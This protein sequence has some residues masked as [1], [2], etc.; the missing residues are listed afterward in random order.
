M[1][2]FSSNMKITCQF[3]PEIFQNFESYRDHIKS[4]HSQDTN[5]NIKLEQITLATEY[6]CNKCEYT[7]IYKTGNVKQETLI[8]YAIDGE[9]YCVDCKTKQ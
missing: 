9:R 4:Q 2:W 5:L 8:L 7:W 6:K 3:C 1:S